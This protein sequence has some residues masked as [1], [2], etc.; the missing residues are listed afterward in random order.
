MSLTISALGDDPLDTLLPLL[1]ACDDTGLGL[2]RVANEKLRGDGAYGPPATSIARLDGEAAGFAV[3]SG[4]HLRV[5]GVARHLR[6]RGIG[7]ALLETAVDRIAQN[8]RHVTLAA[9][10]ANYFTPGVDSRLSD[11][12]AFFARR[13]FTRVD[14]AINLVAKTIDAA[15]SSGEVSIES[16]SSGVREEI[17]RFVADEFGAGWKRE[18]VRAF[19]H[20]EPG[21]VIA[22]H[23]GKLIGFAGYEINNRGLGTF[24]P[25]GV[26]A[27]ARGLGA[28]KALLQAALVDLRRRGY[29]RA[30]I[31]WAAAIPFYERHAGAR[32]LA[33]YQILRRELGPGKDPD[34]VSGQ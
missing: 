3:T 33:R 6:N 28:G 8:H 34:S 30:I 19:D 14:D 15:P 2:E 26:A 20:D 1:R 12:L 21:L 18:A 32:E 31:Q 9:E 16:A 29:A 10:S 24:G 13:G 27:G 7:S 11:A 25:T 4:P 5:L 17:I 23:G 22:R